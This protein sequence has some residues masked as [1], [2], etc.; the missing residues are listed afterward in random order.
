M[1]FLT[2]MALAFSMSMDCFAVSLAVGVS[3]PRLR[4]A[5]AARL[6]LSFGLFQAGMPILGWLGGTAV[7]QWIAD[8]DHWVAFGLLAAV[9]LHMIWEA[10]NGEEHAARS[11]ADRTRGV[12]LLV[13]S[14][15]T[16]IDAL[17]VGVSLS[18][19][20]V[21]IWFPAAVIGVVAA[22]VTAAGTLLGRR[23]G[24]RFGRLAHLLGGLV[25]LAIGLRILLEHLLAG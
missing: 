8:Y 7:R 4:A 13:L 2:L 1:D 14:V 22:G 15:A 24:L 19:Q 10:R 23:V 5:P 6:A 18:L 16:S 17:A 12:A 25:L 20:Q 3:L 11:A 9:G 21:R